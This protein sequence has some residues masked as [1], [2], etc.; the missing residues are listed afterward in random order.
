[1]AVFRPLVTRFGYFLQE[2]RANELN[3]TQWSS[4][5]IYSNSAAGL[6]IEIRQEPFYKDYGFSILIF[7]ERLDEFNI[8]Y[9]VPQEKQDSDGTYW[10]KAA[11]DLF[12]SDDVLNMISGKIW[13]KLTV[14]P[15]YSHIV[16]V[17]NDD[18]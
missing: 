17:C 14:V 4:H 18:E 16:R 15:F 10:Q 8:L 6:K 3:G 5:H 9:N 2:V 13:K 7:N 11:D 12:S 1:M